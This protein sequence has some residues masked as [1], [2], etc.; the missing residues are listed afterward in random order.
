MIHSLAN[1]NEAR[2]MLHQTVG[3]S[4]RQS[5]AGA[6]AWAEW[7]NK[8][9]LVLVVSIM[10]LGSI[11]APGWDAGPSQLRLVTIDNLGWRRKYNVPCSGQLALREAGNSP[12]PQ[13]RLDM[14]SMR[15]VLE[16]ERFKTCVNMVASQ[17]T[18]IPFDSPSWPW[19]NS[20]E[21]KDDS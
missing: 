10:R 13:I 12:S 18:E 7:L 3:P 21:E 5:Y 1:L 16:G 14:V 2:I 4:C 15:I 8:P 20:E 9:G 17:I 19:D 11:T 6:T